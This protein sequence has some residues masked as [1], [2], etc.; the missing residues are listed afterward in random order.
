MTEFTKKIITLIKKIPKGKVSTY[1]QLARL[2]GNP[3]AVKGIVWIHYSQSSS[4]DLP[5]HRVTNAKGKISFPE[6][7]D[8][9]FRQKSLLLKEGIVFSE[10]EKIDLE[11]YAWN[12]QLL[13]EGPGQRN[14]IR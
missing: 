6:M 12:P 13:R 3:Q 2:A 14:L 7:T 5:W 8:H 1:S 4:Q 10:S 11:R 9:W